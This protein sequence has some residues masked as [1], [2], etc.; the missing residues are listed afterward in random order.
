MGTSIF[1][2]YLV[3]DMQTIRVPYGYTFAVT[4][5]PD[6]ITHPG[7]FVSNHI[8]EFSVFPRDAVTP[9]ANCPGKR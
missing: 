9:P 7:S 8:Q 4:C 3:S 2:E 1:P 5:H 6:F